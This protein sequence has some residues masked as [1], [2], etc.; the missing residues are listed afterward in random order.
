MELNIRTVEDTPLCTV[1]VPVDGKIKDIKDEIA[2]QSKSLTTNRQSLRLVVRGNDIENNITLSSLNLQSNSIL[3]VKDLGPQI[4]WR[5]VFLLE[6]AG[7]PFVY[8]YFACRPLYMHNNSITPLSIAARV[9]LVC[10]ISHYIKRLYESIFVHRFSHA[11]MPFKNL[12]RNCGYY[13]GFAAY[14]AIH[15]NHPEYT[16]PC[17]IQLIMGTIVFVF[18]ELGN[19]SVHLLLRDLRPS[20]TNIRQIPMPT[21]NPFTNM[22]NLVSCPNY[23]YEFLAWFGFFIITNSLSA[24]LFA[25][26][27]V[28]QMTL[29]ALVKH[30]AYMK[31]FKDY[32]RRK[33]IIPYLI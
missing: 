13:W 5:T 33:A 27:G 23:T 32:P 10:W 9:A 12:Y 6:Y 31:E 4:G 8:A 19:L 29:W 11:T 20:G 15:I 24:L 30:N 2:K 18:A 25:T 28:A 1:Y 17:N 3:Y 16:P 26:A 21:S 22:Y 7:P 14:I